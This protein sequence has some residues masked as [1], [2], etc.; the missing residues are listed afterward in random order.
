[1]KKP[2]I[3]WIS[4]SGSGGHHVVLNHQHDS[5]TYLAYGYEREGMPAYIEKSAYDELVEALRKTVWWAECVVG[6][7]RNEINWTHLNEGRQA[8]AKHGGSK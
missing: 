6:K 5:T 7:S 4:F 3:K 2:D 1:M 8:L